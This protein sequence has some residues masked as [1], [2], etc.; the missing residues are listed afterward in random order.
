M[1]GISGIISLRDSIDPNL[2]IKMTDVV[3]YRGPDDYG[4]LGVNTCNKIFVS[5]KAIAEISHRTSERNFNLLFGNRRL[6]IID[7]SSAGHQP[8]SYDNG[9]YW[10]TYNGEVYNYVEI[11][12]ELEL[13]GYKFRS[14][15]DTEVIL[16]AYQEWGIDCLC[17][18][19]G[20]WSFAILD[21]RKKIIFLARDHFGIKPCY[22]SHN[23][24]IFSFC[25]EVKQLL[26]L[27]WIRR[28]PHSG[29][30]FDFIAYNKIDH[31]EQTLFDGI[32]ELPA[33]HYI[34][35]ELGNSLIRTIEPRRW[36]DINLEEK[37]DGWSD[38]QYSSEFYNL[39]EDCVRLRLRSDVPIGTSLSGGI[40]SSSIAFV[41]DDLR[42]KKD[43]SKPY[44]TFTLAS[45]YEQFDESDYANEIIKKINVKPHFIIPS[46]RKLF[47]DLER[48][49]WH[50]D[51]PFVSTSIYA[52]WC[53]F[54]M[55]REND[56]K[57]MLDGQG[58]DEMLAGYYPYSLYPSAT[59]TLL[60]FQLYGFLKQVGR[61]RKYFD[62]AMK[63][64]LY[65]IGRQLLRKVIFVPPTLSPG[66]NYVRRVLQKDFWEEGI[67]TSPFV[68]HSRTRLGFGRG[69]ALQQYSYE[70]FFHGSL[71][72]ILRHLDRNAMAFSVEARA[73][74][75]D[76]RLV[77]FIFSLPDDQKMRQ[78]WTKF[79]LREA[80]KEKL[81]IKISSRISKLGFVTAEPEWLRKDEEGSFESLIDSLE[82]CQNPFFVNNSIKNMFREF[83]DGKRKFDTSIWSSICVLLW[84]DKFIRHSI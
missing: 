75:L 1:C 60:H 59:E 47:A 61:I 45:E 15:T 40:D 39:F 19:N 84:Y 53:I 44:K 7:L 6:A 32:L 23:G 36:W 72:W 20:M 2:V 71:N 16:A 17:K 26:T 22:Y 27:P 50:Q 64:Q 51:H 46:A 9:R 33:A 25:S 68:K 76:H 35:V 37:I 52:S 31:S 34:I 70:M 8:M 54:E 21:L 12:N 43:I 79:V 24:T 49:V 3:K 41:V 83:T 56:I 66:I 77:K 81:P 48:L 38:K 55:A 28:E 58:A 82:K 11:R 69:T 30:V 62:V 14:E 42:K 63:D 13:K 18:F 57:V 10:I 67:A 4:Y 65:N 80:M 78:H 73:P 5:F 29:A 74:Y